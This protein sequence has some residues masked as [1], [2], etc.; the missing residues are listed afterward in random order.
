LKEIDDMKKNYEKLAVK[1]NV[2]S[3]EIKRT[4]NVIL[5]IKSNQNKSFNTTTCETNESIKY[6]D[7]KNDDINS[8]NIKQILNI[9]SSNFNY[10]FNDSTKLSDKII[11]I[12][13]H[14]ESLEK[15]TSTK[16]DKFDKSSE[17]L[18]HSINT[19]NR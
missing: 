4:E 8:R 13:N 1:L 5:D 19:I 2:M 11:K 12:E 10:N 14:I 15:M 7:Y 17:N 3:T 18:V 9:L 6:S 16:L